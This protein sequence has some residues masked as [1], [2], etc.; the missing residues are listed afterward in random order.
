MTTTQPWPAPP[1]HVRARTWPAAALGIL[2]TLLAASALIVALARSG[3][4]SSHTYTAAQKAEAKTELCERYKLSG[5]AMHIETSSD[6]IALA[7]LALSNGALMLE[8]AAANPA[9]D[10]KYRDAA[11]A[12]ADSYQTQAAMGTTGMATREQYLA[13]VDDTNAKDRAMQGLCGD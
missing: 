1:P 4:S 5:Q 13:T 3:P 7:R 12:L 6:D 2:T 8:R 9:L 11:R 10:G